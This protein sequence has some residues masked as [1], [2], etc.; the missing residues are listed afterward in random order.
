[1]GRERG[2]GERVRV[3]PQEERTVDAPRR[4]ILADRLRRGQDVGLV[5]RALGGRASMARGAEGD[6]LLG[7][8]RVRPF[9]EVVGDEAGN[10]DEHPCLRGF[11]CQW[12]YVHEW[13]SM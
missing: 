6:L 11:S 9:D 10:V 2:L 12:I 1:R 13:S 4:A 3:D 5:E 8:G 7:K